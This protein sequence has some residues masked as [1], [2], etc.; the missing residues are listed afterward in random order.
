MFCLRP[1]KIRNHPESESKCCQ[2]TNKILQT[3][4]INKEEIFF[5]VKKVFLSFKRRVRTLGVL[6][7]QIEP[8]KWIQHVW[9]GIFIL[10]TKE[11]VEIWLKH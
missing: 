9:L 1:I 8:S 6:G 11:H 7:N 3:L 4:D 5:S 2:S 10:L